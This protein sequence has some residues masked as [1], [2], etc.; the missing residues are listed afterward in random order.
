MLLDKPGRDRKYLDDVVPF[1]QAAIA[2]AIAGKRLYIEHP[3]HR[4]HTQVN[5]TG[6]IEVLPLGGA[7]L[8]SNTGYSETRMFNGVFRHTAEEA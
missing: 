7:V 1:C 6:A 3:L 5:E 8:C 4:A 2:V